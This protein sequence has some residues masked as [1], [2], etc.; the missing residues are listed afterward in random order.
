MKFE[1]ITPSEKLKPYVKYFIISENTLENIYKVLPFP[2]IVIGFQYSGHLST[3]HNNKEI[4]LSASGITG[5]TDKF[6]VFKNSSHTATI[7]VYFTE[8]GFSYF[9]SG[10]ANELFNQSISLDYL[11]NK[12][13]INETE[14]KLAFAKTSVQRIYI[15]EQFLLSQLKDVKKDMLITEA[16]K[17]YSYGK[18][19]Y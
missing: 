9:S 1:K 11:F 18:R 8:T 16:V 12:N 19:S 6:K 10:P 14:D 5:I 17:T 13:K 7:L 3:I 2:N 15:I 4:N